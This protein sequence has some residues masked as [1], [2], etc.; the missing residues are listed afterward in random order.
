MF[1]YEGVGGN[2]FVM[3]MFLMPKG[4]NGS[5]IMQISYH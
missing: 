3:Q 4:L 2:K 1:P 5:K